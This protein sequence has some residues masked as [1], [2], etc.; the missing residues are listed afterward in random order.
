MRLEVFLFF[1]FSLLDTELQINIFLG[2][3]LDSDETESEIDFL[4]HDH[5]LSIDTSVHDIDLGDDTDSPNT[6]WIESSCGSDTF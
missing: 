1:R 3:V 4:V 2:S 6:F 5:S